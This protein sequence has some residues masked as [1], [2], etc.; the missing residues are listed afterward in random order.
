M[1]KR[2]YVIAII[3][4]LLISTLMVNVQAADL[5]YTATMDLSSKNVE[6]GKEFTVTLNVS[7]IK[8]GNKGIN[9][10]SG[11]LE[12]DN[13]VFEEITSDSVEGIND[14]SATY[15]DSTGKI[16]LLKT[17]FVKEDENLCQ[18]TLKVKDKATAK[19]GVIEFK[20]IV[21]SNSESEITADDISVEVTIGEEDEESNTNTNKNKNNTI[22]ITSNKNVNKNNTNTNTNT[23]KNTNSNVNK[24]TNI[25]SNINKNNNSTSI[26][27]SNRNNTSKNN[28]N[29]ANVNNSNIANQTTQEEMPDTGIDDTIVKAIILVALVGVVGYIKMKSLDQ[30]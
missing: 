23:N 21:A 3:I 12:F 6:K 9:S 28:T 26:S 14:W 17:S 7:N 11:Y 27:S 19:K 5:S 30:K 25:S 15:S 24:N 13:K 8:A 20:D 1:K 18:I 10:L 29:I 22:S 2:L 4:A 16:T